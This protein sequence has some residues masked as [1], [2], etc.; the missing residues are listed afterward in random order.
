MKILHVTHQYHPAIGGSEQYI[1]ELSEEL[2]L[3]GHR[4]D[5]FT[6]RSSDYQTW[7]DTLKPYENING[8]DVY[9]FSSFQRQKITWKIL[10]IGLD[11]Y[12]KKRSR[13]YQPMVWYGNGPLSPKKWTALLSKVSNYDVCHINLLHYAHSWPACLAAHWKKI[14]I[15]TTPHVHPAQRNTFDFDYLQNILKASAV[16]I[17]VTEPERRF[18]KGLLPLND[19]VLGGNGL[20]LDRYP[21][22]DLTAGR[23]MLG[24]PIDAFV[25]LFLGRKIEYKGLDVCLTAFMGLRQKIDNAYFIAAGPET[26]YSTNL[27]KNG[28]APDSLIV[29]GRVN[30]ETKRAVLSSADVLVLP[31]V[32]EAFGIV[33]LEAWA[34]RKPVIGAAI[35]S[36][37]SIVDD[38]VNGYLVPPHNARLVEKR[39]LSMAQDNELRT[40]LGRNG[41]H[42]L[43]S[44]FTVEALADVVEG[45]YQRIR[46]THYDSGLKFNQPEYMGQG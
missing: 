18:I 11:R 32:G 16:T 33:F 19:I 31:S 5:V 1:T 22:I 14:P 23:R 34:Y 12:W 9:R 45:T 46:R 24:I 13:I 2:V 7:S 42:K 38:G 36:V 25:M 30:E 27:W 29:L 39:L 21:A 17:A 3:R 8:V 35:P 6:T 41:R 26:E 15:V 43:E 28:P 37:S 4:V 10:G 44:R 20:H 40:R